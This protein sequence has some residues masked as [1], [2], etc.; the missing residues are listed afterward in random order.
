VT[1]TTEP[2]PRWR[3]VAEACAYSGIKERTMRRWITKG[4]LPATRLGP[5]RIQV[6]L[7]EVDKLRTPITPPPDRSDHAEG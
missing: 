1:V 5:R 7:N 6:D 3:T 4:R 2:E